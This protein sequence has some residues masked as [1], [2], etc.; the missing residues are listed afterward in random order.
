[1]R[2]RSGGATTAVVV[3]TVE[4][5]DELPGDLVAPGV[6]GRPVDNAVVMVSPPVVPT[7]GM[8]PAELLGRRASATSAPAARAR[9]AT[10]SNGRSI[11]R[12]RRGHRPGSTTAATG[13]ATMPGVGSEMEGP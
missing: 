10:A 1:M 12:R 3:S 13:S 5:G 11:R 2:L 6:A 9:R 4:A 8:V 7:G